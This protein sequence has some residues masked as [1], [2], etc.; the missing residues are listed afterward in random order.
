MELQLLHDFLKSG[1]TQKTFAKESGMPINSLA[2]KLTKQLRKLEKTKVINL[3]DYV[4]NKQSIL[5]VEVRNKSEMWLRAI[6]AYNNE[7]REIET[8]KKLSERHHFS[9][10]E[11]TQISRWFDK[12]KAQ[13]P[14]L[15]EGAD[16]QLYSKIQEIIQNT[17][18]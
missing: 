1:K 9:F 10:D 17:I 12:L 5:T 3:S 11:V 4:K 18:I 15:V 8:Q 16:R 14:D 7:M 2:T 6:E 13:N